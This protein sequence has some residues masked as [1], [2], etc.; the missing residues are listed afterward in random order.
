MECGGIQDGGTGTGTWK[1]DDDPRMES[2]LH[3]TT[4]FLRNA[5]KMM[6]TTKTRKAAK[7]T[8]DFTAT[9]ERYQR[10]ESS[11]CSRFVPS[12]SQPPHLDVH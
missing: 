4:E 11:R 12:C 7:S 8:D 5:M 10:S 2:V 9:D 1:R 6:K 3:E